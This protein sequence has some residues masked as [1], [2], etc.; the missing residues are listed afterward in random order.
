MIYNKVHINETNQNIIELYDKSIS[1]EKNI[2]KY[3]TIKPGPLLV[4]N[5][6]L[7]Y[8]MNNLNKLKLEM[9]FEEINL[10]FI[11]EPFSP[12]EYLLYPLD[13][14][15]IQTTY[16]LN[17]ISLDIYKR[18]KLM[19]KNMI[20]PNLFVKKL[21]E[22]NYRI[23]VTENIIQGTL[24]FEIGGKVVTKEQINFNNS[25][26][27][28][29]KFCFFHFYPGLNEQN[30]RY[31]LINN[32]GNIGYFLQKTDKPLGNNVIL[33]TYINEETKKLCLLCITCRKIKKGETLIVY[34]TQY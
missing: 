27:L 4:E 5:I 14:N 7:K 15:K 13:S 33:R 30:S 21:P 24:L 2:N 29:R 31:I 28:L 20:Y 8:K 6:N 25:T 22:Y 1:Y 26:L 10:N 18:T 16:L 19:T 23:E 17:N 9:M 32:E 11:D 12:N 34:D 3:G